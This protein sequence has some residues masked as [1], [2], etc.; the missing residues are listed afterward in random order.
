MQAK[1]FIG[2][3]FGGGEDWFSHED[4]Q[5]REELIKNAKAGCEDAKEELRRPPYNLRCLV[6]QGQKII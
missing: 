5:H 1:D 4:R 6:L 2:H 3:K